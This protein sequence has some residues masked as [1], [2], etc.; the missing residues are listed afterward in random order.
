M[1]LTPEN[2][3]NDMVD[4]DPQAHFEYIIRELGARGLAYVHVLQGDMSAKSSVVDYR[5]LRA[6]FAGTYIANNGY[7]LARAKQAIANGEAD[8]VAFGL[9]FLANPDLVRRYRQGLPLN[10]ADPA[11][12]YGGDDAGY[13]DYP[14]FTGEEA[15]AA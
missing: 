7:D 5:A 15:S 9:P 12:F 2:S 4:S 1:R 6:C 11:T 14:F 10:T 8:L 3:F 13:T